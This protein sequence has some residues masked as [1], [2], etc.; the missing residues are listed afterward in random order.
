VGP[1]DPTV[2][3]ARAT[4]TVN[5]LADAMVAARE[6]VQANASVPA[7]EPAGVHAA[8]TALMVLIYNAPQNFRDTVSAQLFLI[9]HDFIMTQQHPFF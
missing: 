5:A 8:H 3:D 4:A 6:D 7:G 2:P 9:G 1:Q